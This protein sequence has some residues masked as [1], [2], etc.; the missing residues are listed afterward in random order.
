ML[1]NNQCNSN[2]IIFPDSVHSQS[3]AEDEEII[4]R[5]PADQWFD[6]TN[7]RD[8]DTHRERVCCQEIDACVEKL[9]DAIIHYGQIEPFSCITLHPGFTRNCLYWEVLENAWL[10]YKQ[11]YGAHAYQNNNKHKRYRHVAYRQLSRFLFGLVGRENRY[12][13]PCCAVSAIR[14]QF[15]SLDDVYTGYNSE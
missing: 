5:G 14:K 3:G 10:S 8:M 1:L 6:C 4:Q 2:G 12:V 15:H 7:C 13:L 9:D 11:H